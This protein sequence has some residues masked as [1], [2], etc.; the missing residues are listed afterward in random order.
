MPT[1]CRACRSIRFAIRR[2]YRCPC[3][4]TFFLGFGYAEVGNWPVAPLLLKRGGI[5]SNDNDGL[6]CLGTRAGGCA[7]SG[8]AR[9]PNT[10]HQGLGLLRRR[11]WCRR[12]HRPRGMAREGR[13]AVVL[14]APRHHPER[15]SADLDPTVIHFDGRGG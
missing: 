11:L 12:W 1:I 3:P 4:E 8:Q 9:T 6:P 14:A 7:E 5:Y 10:T 15:T 13:S 2:R